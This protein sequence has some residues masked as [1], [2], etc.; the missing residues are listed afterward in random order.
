MSAVE[1]AIRDLHAAVEIEPSGTICAACSTQRGSGES[2]R[3]FP[4]T[5]WP[6]ETVMVLDEVATSQ[7]AQTEPGGERGE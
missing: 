3:Y 6:C 7:P 4:Y 1:D 2:V 5:E